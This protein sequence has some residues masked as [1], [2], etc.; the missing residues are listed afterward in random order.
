MKR[1]IALDAMC[2]WEAM[3]EDMQSPSPTPWL[4]AAFDEVGTSVM[5]EHCLFLA[6]H[7]D[8][9]FQEVGK[10]TDID[11]GC[12]DWEFCPNVIQC[13]KDGERLPTAQEVIDHYRY[14]AGE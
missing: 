14:I 1:H 12:F 11:L 3:L 9:L 7:L 5:R 2:L 6:T 13:M 4:K 10:M 8:A